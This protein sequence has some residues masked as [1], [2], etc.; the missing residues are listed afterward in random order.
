[1]QQFAESAIDRS[2]WIDGTHLERHVSETSGEE[3]KV[4][5]IGNAHTKKVLSDT[6]STTSRLIDSDKNE[7]IARQCHQKDKDRNRN[8]PNSYSLFMMGDEI[9]MEQLID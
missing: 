5:L 2:G 1:V 8:Q 6:G 7:D 9:R 3:S 4:Q